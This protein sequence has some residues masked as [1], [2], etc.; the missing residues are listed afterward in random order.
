MSQTYENGLNELDKIEGVGEFD[1][2][3]TEG[4][5]KEGETTSDNQLKEDTNSETDTSTLK[6]KSA[7][8]S[9][10]LSSDN[11]RSS[12]LSVATTASAIG[13]YSNPT[14]EWTSDNTGCTATF[15]LEDGSTTNKACTVT[16]ETV[17]ASCDVD[18]YTLYTAECVYNDQ[19]Y[20]TNRR[21]LNQI[22]HEYGAPTFTWTRTTDGDFTCTAKFTCDKC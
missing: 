20:V 15:T 7:N 9:A 10:S 17:D 4:V 5:L 16:S 19:T 22:D 21:V 3:T 18:G 8:K 2:A 6:K 12:E 13:S 11:A 1:T 14:F